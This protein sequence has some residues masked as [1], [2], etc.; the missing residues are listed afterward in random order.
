MLMRIFFNVK[1]AVDNE[2]A[3]KKVALKVIIDEYDARI[4]DTTYV[5]RSDV[6]EANGAVV[7]NV[8][9]T[10]RNAINS[11]YEVLLGMTSSQNQDSK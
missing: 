3:V 8:I 4:I 11:V 5:Q 9:D 7:L 2:Y 1:N 6:L 10:T